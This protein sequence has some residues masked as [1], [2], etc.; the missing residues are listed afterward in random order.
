MFPFGVQIK[1]FLI[2]L[3]FAYFVLPFLQR[4]F[5]NKTARSVGA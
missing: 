4:L 1:G 2:G 3:I 5:I